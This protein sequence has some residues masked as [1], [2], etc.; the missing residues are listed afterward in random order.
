VERLGDVL[1]SREMPAAS[2]TIKCQRCGAVNEIPDKKTAIRC[3]DCYMFIR[4]GN[5][6]NRVFVKH[7]CWA[8][9]D[10]GLIE[11]EKQVDSILYKSNCRCTCDAGKKWPLDIL[12]WDRVVGCPNIKFFEKKNKKEVDDKK[13]IYDES[14][15]TWVEI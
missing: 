14:G 3:K 5:P 7:N 11:Y 6:K 10:T 9:L 15:I 13:R 8:C 12:T 4:L 2:N 1:T